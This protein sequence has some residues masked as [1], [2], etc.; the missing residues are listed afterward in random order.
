MASRTLS[1]RKLADFIADKLQSGEAE[2]VLKQAAAYLI[3]TKQTGRVELLVREIESA[4]A[5]RGTVVADVTSARLLK[6]AEKT[7]IAKLLGTK[8]LQIRENIDPTVLGGVRIEAAGRLLDA[9]LKR[10]IDLLKETELRRV[11]K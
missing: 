5:S 4:L 8:N 7:E 6:N 11:A 1:R 3:E 9:T 10:K 2:D